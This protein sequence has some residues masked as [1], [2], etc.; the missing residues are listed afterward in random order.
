M[1]E[2]LDKI[3]IDR[4][5]KPWT[6][7]NICLNWITDNVICSRN[8]L[9]QH[10][11]Y[12]NK[13][14]ARE[15]FHSVKYSC[16][17]PTDS[18]AWWFYEFWNKLVWIREWKKFDFDSCNF[19]LL[20]RYASTLIYHAGYFQSIPF[21]V[22]YQIFHNKINLVISSNNTKF[23]WFRHVYHSGILHSFSIN[24]I[25]LTIFTR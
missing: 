15:L 8:R 18:K 6:L 25:L 24:T 7:Q 9:L 17:F 5:I 11:T 1:K 23:S 4:F 13:L 22:H 20:T 21:K 19:S 10:F 2:S 16:I 14:L 12:K 3:S